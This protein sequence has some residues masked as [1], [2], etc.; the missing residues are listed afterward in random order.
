MNSRPLTKVSSIS[1]ALKATT[2]NHFLISRA[3]P[4]L[5]CGVFADK[6]IS[7]NKR[8]RQTQVIINQVW[9][10]GYTSTYPALLLV[11]SGVK[12]HTMSRLGIWFWSSMRRPLARV[13]RVFP[14]LC[15]IQSRSW[16][17]WRSV[18]PKS[19]TGGRMSRLTDICCFSFSLSLMRAHVT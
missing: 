15:K 5:P 12:A 16:R 7:I 3:N 10:I 8:R 1:R 13:M 19:N 11:G 6:E 9:S 17:C 4:M 14:G 2:P 18:L